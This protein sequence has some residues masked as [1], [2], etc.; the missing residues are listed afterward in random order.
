MYAYN[1]LFLAPEFDS[2][3]T[4]EYSY[5]ARLMG[6]L[7]EEGLAR[8]GVKIFSKVLIHKANNV[9]LLKVNVLKRKKNI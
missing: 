7:P 4:Y 2:D 3:K 5:E 6:G 1:K 8:A 9:I